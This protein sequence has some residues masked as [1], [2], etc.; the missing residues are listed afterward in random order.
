MKQH[1]LFI[2][3]DKNELIFFLDALKRVP[4]HDG[5]KYTYASNPGQA[6]EM[7]KFLVPDFIFVD[8]NFPGMNGLDFTTIITGQPQLKH[9]KPVLYSAGINERIRTLAENQGV[10]C[11]KKAAL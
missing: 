6:L 5:F 2:N 1:I 7:L 3:E 8:F 10:G 11:V 9:T 4:Y